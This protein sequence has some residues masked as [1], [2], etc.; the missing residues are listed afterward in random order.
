MGGDAAAGP[1]FPPGADAE[2]YVVVAQRAD[3]P[4]GALLRVLYGDEA[5]LLANVD[6]QVYALADDCL[7]AGAMLSE[8]L[9]RAGAV[10][11]PWH[12]WRYDAATGAVLLPRGTGLCTTTYAVRVD[13]E[14]IAVGPRRPRGE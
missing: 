13:G 1:P 3:V 10:I 7:H 14:A 12:A 2:G 4:P 5:V 6:G 11:C 9:L 8:G